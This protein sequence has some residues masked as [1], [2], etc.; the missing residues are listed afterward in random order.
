MKKIKNVKQAEEVIAKYDPK[1]F[2]DF[3]RDAWF[4]SGLQK[5]LYAEYLVRKHQNS[6][7]AEPKAV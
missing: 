4:S 7:A 2:E 6:P 5:E 1:F 3:E